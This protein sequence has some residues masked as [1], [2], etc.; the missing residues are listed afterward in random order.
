[1]TERKAYQYAHSKY[2]H[3]PGWILTR[4]LD[5]THIDWIVRKQQKQINWKLTEN[6][7]QHAVAAMSI[8]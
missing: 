7:Y 1:M 8:F 3:D 2:H 4:K 6:I 5:D